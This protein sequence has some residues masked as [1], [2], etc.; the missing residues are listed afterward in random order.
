MTDPAFTKDSV[1]IRVIWFGPHHKFTIPATSDQ[2]EL[3][4]Y[5]DNFKQILLPETN[6]RQVTSLSQ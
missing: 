2:P 4:H 3:T 1:I 5:I 6:L